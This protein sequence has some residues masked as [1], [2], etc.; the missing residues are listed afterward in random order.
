MLNAAE[1]FAEVW[2]LPKT[3]FHSFLIDFSVGL[4]HSSIIECWG[5]SRYDT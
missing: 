5:D 1:I 4:F 2:I 3:I